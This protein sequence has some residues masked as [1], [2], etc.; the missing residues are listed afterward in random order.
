MVRIL[1]PHLEQVGVAIYYYL[2]KESLLKFRHLGSVLSI[3]SPTLN[4]WTAK[5]H[6]FV[7]FKS[8]DAFVVIFYLMEDSGLNLHLKKVYGSSEF[9][10]IDIF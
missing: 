1:L 6:T 9:I 10:F 8:A 4:N 3:L 7:A 2:L 5:R